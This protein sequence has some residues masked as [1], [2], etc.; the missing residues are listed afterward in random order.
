MHAN[1]PPGRLLVILQRPQP[2]PMNEGPSI[3]SFLEPNI[4]VVEV[5]SSSP[6]KEKEAHANDLKRARGKEKV[7]ED[8]MV[9]D[10]PIEGRRWKKERGEASKRRQRHINLQDFPL[11]HGMAPY[12]LIEDL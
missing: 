10:T 4:H 5:A 9:E 11:G 8:T 7:G 12:S 3:S 2:P 1:D 6:M